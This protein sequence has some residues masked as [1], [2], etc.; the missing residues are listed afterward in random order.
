M[1]RWG[2]GSARPA[3]FTVDDRDH[4]RG[5]ST[6]IRRVTRRFVQN[7]TRTA[8]R[9]LPPHGPASTP[10]PG[11]PANRGGA[12]VPANLAIAGKSSSTSREKSLDEALE[13]TFRASNPIAS[14]NFK[15]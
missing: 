6:P 2:R 3:S 4:P 13:C 14:M 10:A 1:F 8:G 5:S 11:L 12:S 9:R 7:S 15:R